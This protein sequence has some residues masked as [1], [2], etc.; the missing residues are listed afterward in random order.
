MHLEDPMLALRIVLICLL[1]LALPSPF[2]SV[3][4]VD[5][6]ITV[7]NCSND[8]Q[9]RNAASSAGVT[10]ISFNCGTSTI[11]FSSYIQVQGDVT[12]DGADKITFDG[13]SSQAFF[14]VFSSGKLVLRNL[15][16]QN[17]KFNASHVL[18]NFG[19]LQLSRVQVK[20]NSAQSSSGGALVNYGTLLIEQSNFSENSVLGGASGILVGGAILQESG[21]ST[22]RQTTFSDNKVSANFALG[23]AI[24]LRD[25]SL[26]IEESEFK[27]NSAADGGAL[28]LSNTTVVSLTH[29]LFEENSASYGGA[30]VSSGKLDIAYSRFSNNKATEGD[31]GAIWV[32]GNNAAISNSSF[33]GNQATTTG[34]AVSC[35]LSN[36]S[37]IHST[38]NNNQAGSN[39]GGVYST[40]ALTIG[41]ST[42][43][44]N[45]APNGGGGGI[46]H[47]SPNNATAA[48]LTIVDNSAT[49]GAGVYNESGGGGSFTIRQSILANNSTGNCD[50]VVSSAGYNISTDTNCANF[51]QTGDKQAISLTLGPLASNGGPT[52]TH[53]PPAGSPAIDAVPAPCAFSV[54]QRNAPRPF[55]SA[56]DIGAVEVGAIAPPVGT[57]Y[58]VYLPLV[59]K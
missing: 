25:G 18:E 47:N 55:G 56:C 41:N 54:D 51:T 26:T 31:G 33:N 14:Q 23:G 40:C 50:G 20:R 48:A 10:T 11:P 45:R 36:L 27:R 16:L 9:L 13:G 21:T 24:A 30:I 42:L 2:L 38:L 17:G 15:T 58:I 46:Y 7:T 12:I 19:S 22:I 35:N 1:A 29:T 34:G 8:T 49:F 3:A 37:I 28:S 32:T 44:G 6:A 52:F 39:G 5:G 53:L 57:D 59:R 43:S 4:R